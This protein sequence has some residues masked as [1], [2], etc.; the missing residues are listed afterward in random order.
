MELASRII[1]GLVAFIHLYIFIFESFAWVAR[2]PKVFGS[3]P[4]DLF[5]QTVAM[6]KNMGAYNLCLG[7]GLIWSFFICDPVWQANVSLFFLGCVTFVGIIGAVTAERKIFFVQSLP[8]IIGIVLILL[9][10]K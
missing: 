10:C 9:N 4:K 5:P 8:A 6:A 3:F 1:V 7:A 2:G